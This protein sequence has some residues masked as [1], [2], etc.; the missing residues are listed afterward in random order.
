VDFRGS[1]V[2]L[3]WIFVDLSS[4]FR[5][6]SVGFRRFASIFVE[7]CVCGGDSLRDLLCD[8]GFEDGLLKA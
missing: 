4:I 8:D 2:D 3:L 7:V 5:G 6:S 1:F